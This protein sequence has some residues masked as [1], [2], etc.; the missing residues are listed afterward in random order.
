MKGIPQLKS[1][2][3]Y[4]KVQAE[5]ISRQAGVNVRGTGD[6]I[7]TDIQSGDWISVFGADFSKGSKSLTICA[8]SQKEA[9]V[10][11]CVGNETGKAIGYAVIPNSD[12]KF[13][14]ITVPVNNISGN[15]D[16]YFIF[17]DTIELDWWQFT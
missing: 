7:I 6:T 9:I 10:K 5:T 1:L 2:N 17:S 14:E 15:Q 11:I 12:G 16:I 8:S 4:E 3:P 13:T